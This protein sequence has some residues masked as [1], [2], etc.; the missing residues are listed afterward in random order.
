MPLQRVRRKEALTKAAFHARLRVWLSGTGDEQVGDPDVQG[1]TAWVYVRDGDRLFRLHADAKRE[2]VRAYLALV[3]ALG[4][5][6]AWLVVPN[7]RGAR[8]AVAHGPE[9]ERLRGFYFYLLE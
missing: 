7:A 2:A 1:R 5:G 4:D 8:N 9:L 6:L 3:D